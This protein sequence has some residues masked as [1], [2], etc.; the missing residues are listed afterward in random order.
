[1][2]IIEYIRSSFG[3][4]SSQPQDWA[5]DENLG[6]LIQHLTF[7]AVGAGDQGFYSVLNNMY[8]RYGIRAWDFVH[9]D[10]VTRHVHHSTFRAWRGHRYILP[11][12]VVQ[13]YKAEFGPQ[14][15]FI[16]GYLKAAEWMMSNGTDQLKS[17]YSY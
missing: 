7:A 5:K 9:Y 12:A 10:D 3:V 17:T 13:H 4:R 15:H 2:E 16:A 11:D 14:N 1:M 6:S 8:E